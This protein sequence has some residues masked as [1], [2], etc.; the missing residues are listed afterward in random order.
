[1]KYRLLLLFL[2]PPDPVTSIGATINADTSM[3]ISWSLP[4]DPSVVRVTIIRDRLD[5]LEG[6]A[7]FT[8]NGAPVSYTDTT[9]TPGES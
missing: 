4:A 9:A 1:M 8:L 7:V 2:S 6:N 3:T 5:V